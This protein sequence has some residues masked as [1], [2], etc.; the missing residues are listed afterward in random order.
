M[1]Y[2]LQRGL[3]ARDRVNPVRRSEARE[4]TTSEVVEYES[5]SDNNME[6][7]EAEEV[8]SSVQESADGLIRTDEQIDGIRQL[9]RRTKHHV[10]IRG[11]RIRA[12]LRQVFNRVL[13][14]STGGV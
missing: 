13:R 4:E 14:R 9:V 7:R 2:S 12:R 8:Q 3:M 6:S 10:Y 5:E 11:T 1:A